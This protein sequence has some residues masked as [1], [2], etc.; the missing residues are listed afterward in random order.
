MEAYSHDLGQRLGQRLLKD[1][2]WYKFEGIMIIHK[3]N[4]QTYFSIGKFPI[5][6]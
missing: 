4:A 1:V 6:L 3:W 2:I 5:S